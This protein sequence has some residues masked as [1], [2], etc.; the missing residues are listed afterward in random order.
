MAAKNRSARLAELHTDLAATHRQMDEVVDQM[1]GQHGDQ[2]AATPRH[3]VRLVGDAADTR[4]QIRT[5]GG[6]A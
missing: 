2:L 5:L 4:A 3:A 1:A 6:V